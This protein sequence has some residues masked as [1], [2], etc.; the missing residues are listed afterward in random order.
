MSLV[1]IM[2]LIFRSPKLKS[3]P[4]LENLQEFHLDLCS[5]R[6]CRS[7]QVSYLWII[8]GR[9][10]NPN[11]E[12][13]YLLEYSEYEAENWKKYTSGFYIRPMKYLALDTFAIPIYI[14]FTKTY[15]FCYLGFFQLGV[16][17]GFDFPV[18]TPNQNS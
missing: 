6:Y 2:S 3:I 1:D 7:P 9:G 11:L 18:V 12:R 13:S 16:K 10:W 5:S 15:P 17:L 14:K 4:F 8:S